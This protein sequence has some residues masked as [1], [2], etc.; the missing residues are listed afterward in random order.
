MA[1]KAKLVWLHI[2]QGPW[3]E[4]E[5]WRLGRGLQGSPGSCTVGLRPEAPAPALEVQWKLLSAH[6][7]ELRA[8]TPHLEE[9]RPAPSEE[10]GGAAVGTEVRA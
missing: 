3:A 8:P 7:T 9:G 10:K 1:I 5:A 2:E 6:P 4:N